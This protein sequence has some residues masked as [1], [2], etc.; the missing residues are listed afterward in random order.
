MALRLA[1]D[2]PDYDP[3]GDLDWDTIAWEEAALLDAQEYLIGQTLR[4]LAPLSQ[5]I[6]SKG[7]DK[8]LS[9][10]RKGNSDG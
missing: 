1:A 3:T 9:W 10:S 2:P 8:H 4:F 5:A 6:I 7:W